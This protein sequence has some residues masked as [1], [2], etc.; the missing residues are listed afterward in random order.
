VLFQGRGLRRPVS[1][2]LSRTSTGPG[3]HF[4]ETSTS[5]CVG[6]RACPSYGPWTDCKGEKRK[7]PFR[8][9][10]HGKTRF[11]CLLLINTTPEPSGRSTRSDGTAGTQWIGHAQS[12]I[13]FA[14]APNQIITAI[15]SEQIRSQTW[16]L[17]ASTDEGAAV[18]AVE[19]MF[20]QC[21]GQEKKIGDLLLGDHVELC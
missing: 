6:A 8:T 3:Q 12:S 10:V 2:D 19:W 16:P 14:A 9:S 4:I 17:E 7:D 18:E 13:L 5:S 15:A 1:S 11:S 21:V 20:V